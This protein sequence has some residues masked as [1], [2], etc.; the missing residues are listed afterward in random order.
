MVAKL[1]KENLD[2]ENVFGSVDKVVGLHLKGK[3]SIPSLDNFFNLF[4]RRKKFSEAK[5]DC[6]KKMF[7]YFIH[8]LTIKT[9]YVT[10]SFIKIKNTVIV[11]A[12]MQKEHL[13]F[14]NDFGTV[15]KVVGSHLKVRSSIPS[16]DNIFII[17][18]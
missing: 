17:S 13:D 12:K 15:D 8:L 5:K 7:D 2:F 3:G 4:S 14:K 9:V 16:L 11:I 10:F 1:Q 6:N 18:F